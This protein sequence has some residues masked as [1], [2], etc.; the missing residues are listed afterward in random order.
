MKQ[1][2]IFFL[3]SK[4]YNDAIYGF[5]EINENINKIYKEGKEEIIKLKD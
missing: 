2:V 1:F 5:N 4:S 3:I